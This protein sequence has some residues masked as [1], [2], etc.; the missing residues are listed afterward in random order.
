MDNSPAGRIGE[1]FTLIK[2]TGK[3]L[4][5]RINEI[6]KAEI[7]NILQSGSVSLRVK[8]N[9]IKAE[10]NIPVTK[11][12]EVF[13]R[14]VGG[15][16]NIKLQFLGYADENPL[17]SQDETNGLQNKI[18][19]AIS[20]FVGARLKSS[21]IKLIENLVKS[22]PENV[23]AS[24]PEFKTLEMFLP[25]IQELYTFLP[26]SWQEMKDGELI[27]KKGKSRY[28]EEESYS[29]TINLDL[30]MAGKLS[31]SVTMYDQEFYVSFR[32]ENPVMESLLISEKDV[33]EKQFFDTGM[34]LRAV[35]FKHEPKIE[36]GKAGS[37][38]ID[39]RI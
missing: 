16:K 23:K 37:T 28:D 20:E 26:L 10:T 2:P 33:L 14:V 11:R 18:F 30:E 39:M 7:L 32:A 1:L 19:K 22:L 15:D 4:S 38:G 13:L 21:D 29:C 3:A 5:L 31:I 36:F 35:N 6:V 17:V 24:Y 8:G 25:K 27:F 34:Q 9:I 12:G